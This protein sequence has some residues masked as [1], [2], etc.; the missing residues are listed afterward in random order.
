MKHHSDSVPLTVF[1]LI[2][3]PADGTNKHQY[4]DHRRLPLLGVG[5]CHDS[6]ALG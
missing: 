5:G 2:D 3:G 1:Q 6:K 4:Y